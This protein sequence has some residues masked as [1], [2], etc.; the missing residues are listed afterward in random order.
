MND[1]NSFVV[2]FTKKP[3]KKG[4]YYYFNIP[5]AFISSEIISPNEKYEIRVF[6]K[7][8]NS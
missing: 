4:K 7:K 2:K 3:T 1:S 8:E 6:K 5:I